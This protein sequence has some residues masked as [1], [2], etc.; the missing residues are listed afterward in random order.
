MPPGSNI[1][2]PLGHMFTQAKH[3]K[4]ILTQTARQRIFIFSYFFIQKT[5]LWYSFEIESFYTCRM[6]T[7]KIGHNPAISLSSFLA[8]DLG[9]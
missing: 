3:K 9:V 4:D 8:Y 5:V 1:A 7:L 6:V 2:P